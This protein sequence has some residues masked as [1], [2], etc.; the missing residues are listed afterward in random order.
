LDKSKAA[1]ENAV[2]NLEAYVKS[3]GKTRLEY[4]SVQLA[5]G[6][7]SVSTDSLAKRA[8][9]ALNKYNKM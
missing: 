3:H 5:K 9:T 4:N 7:A 1:Y 2:D 8:T 6:W